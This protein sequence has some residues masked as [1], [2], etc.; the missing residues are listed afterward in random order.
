MAC[1]RGDNLYEGLPVFPSAAEITSLNVYF[2][3]KCVKGLRYLSSG[4]K[5]RHR[6]DN[7]DKWLT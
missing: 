5:K 3:T 6:P 4:I 1:P 2:W 7:I